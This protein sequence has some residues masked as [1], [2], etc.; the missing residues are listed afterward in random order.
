MKQA[1]LM[2]GCWL[3]L[4][5]TQTMA[6]TETT[7]SYE[8]LLIELTEAN[9]N[10][11][12]PILEQIEATEHPDVLVLFKTLLDGNLN[13]RKADQALI[14]IID[15]N[16]TD[17]YTE[18]STGTAIDPLGR[19][20][21]TKIRVNNNL[22]NYLT[23]AIGR[24]QLTS[25]NPELRKAAVLS[26]LDNLQPST[27]AELTRLRTEEDNRSVLA[28]IDLALAMYSAESGDSTAA[29]ITAIDKLS[30]SLE[31]SARNL[32]FSL[33]RDAE[34]PA[35]QDAATEALKKIDGKVTFYGYVDQL[36]F[37]LSL[38][39]VLLLAAIGLAITF[40]VMGVINM[41]H[42]E[43]LMLGAYTTYVVQLLMPGY[44]N[45]SIWVAIPAAFIVAGLFGILIE[46]CVIRF[47]H[48]RP[49]ETLLATFGISLILQQLVRTVFSPLNR[50][51][52][53]PDWMSGSLEIN[54]VLSLTYNRLT[55]LI[56]AL[57]VFVA[58]LLIMKKT[59]LGLYV[60][61]VSQNRDMA[62]AMGI[63]TDRVDALTF[64]L[65]SGIAGIGGVALSQLTNVG[66][67]LG[68]AYIIDS[69]MVVVFGGVGNLLGTLVAAFTLGI[70]NKFLEPITGT[71][72]ASILVLVFIILF[73]QKRPKGLFP[74]RGRASE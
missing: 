34:D 41:A 26:L 56:F 44:I 19:R 52:A 14:S 18:F 33:E 51:V 8:D 71:V 30:E 29:K 11:T 59:A 73:I 27:A 42:G 53:A 47:L 49:L 23:S 9:L 25:P 3:A 36:F 2:L 64:G 60:R 5:S 20:D 32:L 58:L 63:K 22:R 12:Q 65:G 17:Q 15:I 68:Q 38:G 31:P 6:E 55:I 4:W 67:N 74:Q 57:I 28:S 7:P 48:G 66:P 62:K 54:P 35:V 10:T 21:V 37:G 24:L 39:S 72:L 40:G 45:Y 46:R 61:A 13:F 16:G 50:R 69:F 1:L 43:M 70:A